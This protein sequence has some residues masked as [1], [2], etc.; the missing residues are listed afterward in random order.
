MTTET[1][2]MTPLTDET[3]SQ[4]SGGV[5]PIVVGGVV[6]GWKAIGIGAA[7]VGGTFA[8]GAAAGYYANRP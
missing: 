2:S 8:A 5:V 7:V 6:I 1:T 3:L 4:I